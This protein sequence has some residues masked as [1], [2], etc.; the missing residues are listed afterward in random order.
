MKRKYYI[1]GIAGTGKSAVGTELKKIG[2]DVYDIDAVEGLCHWKHKET[3]VEAKYNTGVG[4]EWL[5]AHDWICDEER[6]KELLSED[7]ERD[8]IVVGIAYNQDKFID[9]FDKVFLFYC[10]PETFIARINTR[11]DGNNFGK[12]KSEQEQLLKWYRDF[13]QKMESLGAIPINTEVSLE[14]VVNRVREEIEKP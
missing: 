6:L 11:T 8:A 3:G 1:T 14:Q 10:S 9:F 5:E 2:Y 12:D 13:Q 4:K 7:S